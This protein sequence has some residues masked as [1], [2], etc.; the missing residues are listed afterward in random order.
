MSVVLKYIE[1]SEF[2][3]LLRENGLVIVHHGELEAN[4]EI[5]RQQL[6]KRKYLSFSEIIN[7]KFFPIKD[8][9]TLRRW[10]IDG[11]FGK[12]GFYQ[13]NNGQFRIVTIALKKVLYGE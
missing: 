11:K 12:D 5:K 4:A 9:N 10:C 13:L 1:A 6:L 8:T 2:M 3:Q 7:A